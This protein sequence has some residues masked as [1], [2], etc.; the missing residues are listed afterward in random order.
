M[1]M[2]RQLEAALHIDAD[3]ATVQALNRFVAALLFVAPDASEPPAGAD[4]ARAAH[5]LAEY[6]EVPVTAHAATPASAAGPASGT[7]GDAGTA[8]SGGVPPAQ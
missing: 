7:G 8:P 4:R 6:V 3:Q 5:S 2:V 1:A